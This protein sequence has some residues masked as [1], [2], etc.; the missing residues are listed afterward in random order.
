MQTADSVKKIVE[1]HRFCYHGNMTSNFPFQK[2][3]IKES[4][5]HVDKI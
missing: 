4:T 2:S 1:I 5:M 3:H